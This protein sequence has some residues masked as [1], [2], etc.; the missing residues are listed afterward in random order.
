MQPVKPRSL[1]YA[2]VAASLLACG[3][4]PADAPSVLGAP[5]ICDYRMNTYADARAA[6]DAGLALSEFGATYCPEY[7][8]HPS[9]DVDGNQI[10]DCWADRS[11]SVE[12]DYMS[13][14]P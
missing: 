2:G 13:P 3:A 10:N 1:I 6:L 12:M 7:K 14:R 8:M 9:W 5:V 11:C 4:G